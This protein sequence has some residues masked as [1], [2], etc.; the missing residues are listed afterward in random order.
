MTTVLGKALDDGG[1]GTWR[2]CVG[3]EQARRVSTQ[4]ARRGTAVHAI[5]EAYLNN[6]PQY[7]VGAMPVNVDMFKRM[8]PVLD[9]RVGKIYGVEAPLYSTT[10]RTAGRTDLAAD[11]DAIPSIVDFKTSRR[12]K[13]EE[14]ILKYFLQLTTY[15]IMFEERTGLTI[16]QIVVIIGIDDEDS[17]VFIKRTADYEQR[18]KEIFS[19]QR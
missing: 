16:P 3:E 12:V 19:A 11:F 17:Q 10:L 7:P 5:C 15:A 14:H 1:L 4:A 2:K 13:L 18:V 9:Q 8:R 6:E